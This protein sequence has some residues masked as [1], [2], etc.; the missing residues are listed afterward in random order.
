MDD[1]PWPDDCDTDDALDVAKRYVYP[2]R[3]ELI[4]QLNHANRTAIRLR[5]TVYHER[6]HRFINELLD[7]IV[8]R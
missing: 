5:D 1:Y 3:E 7:T 2:T 8:G 4:E 6:T